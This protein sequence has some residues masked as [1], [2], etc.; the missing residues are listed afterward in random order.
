MNIVK[1]CK[2]FGIDP[3]SKIILAPRRVDLKN[4]L[5]T[6]INAVPHINPGSSGFSVLIAGGGPDELVHHYREEAKRLASTI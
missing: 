6:L 3:Q 2:R 1:C 4:G 5:M